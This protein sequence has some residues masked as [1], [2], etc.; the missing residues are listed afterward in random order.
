M[1][2]YLYYKKNEVWT[3]RADYSLSRYYFLDGCDNVIVGEQGRSFSFWLGEY[4]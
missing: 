1:I 2:Y 4:T 3:G